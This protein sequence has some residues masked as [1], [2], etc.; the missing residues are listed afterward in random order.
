VTAHRDPAALAWSEYGVDIVIESTGLL[1]TRDQAAA[2]LKAGA[3]KVL[4]SAPGEDIDATWSWAL[5]TP[6]TTRRGTTSSLT[7]VHDRLVKVFGCYDNEWAAATG[8]ST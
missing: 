1:R 2:H 7:Q 5:S 3:R 4:L 8:C 6:R